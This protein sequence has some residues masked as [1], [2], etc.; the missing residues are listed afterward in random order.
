[1]TLLQY[2]HA[3]R[4]HV[5]VGPQYHGTLF[6]TEPSVFWKD[7]SGSVYIALSSNGTRI[8]SCAAVQRADRSSQGRARVR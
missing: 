1:M 2:E 8:T 5:F 6:R 4:L 7:M 3:Y